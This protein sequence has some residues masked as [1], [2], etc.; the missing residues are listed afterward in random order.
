MPEETWRVCDSGIIRRR[1][2]RGGVSF[3]DIG[4]SQVSRGIR[5]VPDLGLALLFWGKLGE[6]LRTAIGLSSASGRPVERPFILVGEDPV[7][8]FWMRKGWTWTLTKVNSFHPC[9]AGVNK[10]LWLD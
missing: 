7:P 3:E 2:K 6:F 4:L 5:R 9:R 1:V 10:A 8:D